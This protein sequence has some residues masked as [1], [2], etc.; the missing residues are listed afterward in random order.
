MEDLVID[1]LVKSIGVSNYTVRHLEEL[2]RESD[3]K[4]TVNQVENHVFLQQL[5]LLEF[6][7]KQDIKV[8]SYSPMAHGRKLKDPTIAGI[9]AK[10]EKTPAQVMIRWCLENGTVPLPKSAT[11][12]RIAEN[13][14][15]FDFKLDTND[16]GRLGMLDTGFRTAWD[17]TNVA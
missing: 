5:D 12:E 10:H 3:I 13:I 6:C 7:D 2:L 15:V 11:P 9:A 4:P 16:I 8:Q 1:G 17:P 14:D